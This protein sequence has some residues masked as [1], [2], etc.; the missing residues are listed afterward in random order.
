VVAIG[1]TGC[2]STANKNAPAPKPGFDPS[3]PLTNYPSTDPGNTVLGY[4][5]L[6]QIGA[7][8]GAIKGYDH[9]VVDA[10]GATDFLQV[11]SDQ[12]SGVALLK[13][14]VLSTDQVP[15]G[16]I[17]VVSARNSHNER[18]TY[19]FELRKIHER[20]F[21]VYDSL[22]GESIVQALQSSN[23]QT[24]TGGTT[25]GDAAK[26]AALKAA[27]TYR[28]AAYDSLPGGVNGP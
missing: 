9:R 16:K 28:R 17:V 6:L 14:T 20:W 24:A 1:A 22:V 25:P 27:R 21:I 10:V 18:G 19:S 3:A 4:W 12:R 23:Q 2:S 13:P 5:R 8:T 26:R 11:L 15:G 7:Y